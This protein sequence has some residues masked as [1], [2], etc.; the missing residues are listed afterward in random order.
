[1][2]LINEVDLSYPIILDS[3]RRVMDGMHRVAKALLQGND[4]IEAVQFDSDPEPAFSS[5]TPRDRGAIFASS[6]GPTFP[7]IGSDFSKDP[8]DHRGGRPIA[9]NET[10]GHRPQ[11][12]TGR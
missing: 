1:M 11:E 7:C 6:S 2:T 10:H 5:P 8:E 3:N 9:Q 12:T 4:V